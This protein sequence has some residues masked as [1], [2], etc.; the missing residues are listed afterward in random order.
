MTHLVFQAQL[1]ALVPSSTDSRSR[2]TSEAAETQ[3][4]ARALRTSLEALN[5]VHREQTELVRKAEQLAEGDD[6]SRRISTI[7]SQFDQLAEVSPAMFENVFDE[8]LAKYDRFLLDM[9][10]TEQ[11]QNEL[12]ANIEVSYIFLLSD[13][14]LMEGVRVKTVYFCK[15]DGRTRLSKNANMPYSPLTLVIRSIAKL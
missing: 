4:H 12:L 6:I 5:T 9:E 14:S 13:S 3:R 2:L 10:K 15:A 1:E 7:A 11:K 8:E